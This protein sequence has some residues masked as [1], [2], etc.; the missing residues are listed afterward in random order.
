MCCR[1][2]QRRIALGLV[3]HLPFWACGDLSVTT[4]LIKEYRIPL[5]LTVE[6]YR[7]AQLYMIAVSLYTF[8]EKSQFLLNALFWCCQ[9]KS[10]EESHGEGSG[11]EIIVNEPYQNGPGGN[12]QYTKKIYHVGS[13]LPGTEILTQSKNWVVKNRC[14]SRVVQESASQVGADGRGGG[15]ERLSVHQNKIHHTLCWK[16]LYRNRNLLLWRQWASG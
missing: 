1:D 14:L 3:T 13:H 11:V 6:E 4:M 12:G 15:L 16:V 5:P 7:I 9:K 8:D 10:R 2:V